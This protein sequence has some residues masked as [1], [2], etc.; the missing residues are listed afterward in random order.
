MGLLSDCI[1]TVS[2]LVGQDKTGT[3]CNSWSGQVSLEDNVRDCSF[4]AFDMEMSGLNPKKDFI[5]S[6][7]AIKM[8]G[9]RIHAGELAATPQL[10]VNA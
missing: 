5:I 8:T 3:E 6:I 7:G 4:V 10:A 2:A 9:G 1:Q